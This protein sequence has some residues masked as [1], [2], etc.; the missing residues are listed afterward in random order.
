MATVNHLKNKDAQLRTLTTAF[1]KHVAEGMLCY[2]RTVG[3]SPSHQIYAYN[4]LGEGE[5]DGVE[6]VWYKGLNIPAADYT[7]HPGAKATDMTSGDQ[8]VDPLF[9][10]D[11]PH[12]RTAAIGYKIPSGIGD[13]DTK[14]SP[15]QDF[16]SICRTKKCYDYKGGGAI[17]GYGY[18]ANPAREIMQLATDYARLPNLPAQWAD[19]IEY[20]ISRIDWTNWAEWRDFCDQT[21]VVDYLEIP[22]FEGLGLTAEYYSG[23]NFDTFYT[24]RVEPVINL[25]TGNGSPA[26]GLSNDNF[27]ARFEGRI[28]PKYT[29]TYTFT[30]THDN[31][32]RLWINNLSTPLINQWSDAGTSTPGTHT[33]TI[34]LTAGQPYDIKL[35]W[36]NATHPSSFMLQWNS[37]TQ[38]L[39]V[40]PSKCLYPKIEDRPR[41]ES[42]VF[43]SSPT[44]FADS[45]RQILFLS[46]SIMQPVNGK[47]RFFC[48][49]QLTSSFDFDSS[50]MI[51][52]TFNFTN[53]NILQREPITEFEAKFRDLDSQYLEEPA[54]P[55]S[56]KVDGLARKTRENVKV[57][58]LFNMTN[59]QAWKV[60]KLRAKLETAGGLE[61]SFKGQGSKVYTPLPGDLVT[62]T[63]RKVG[64]SA[65]NFLLVE[66]TDDAQ[67]Q[68]QS[69]VSNRTFV[70][71]EW[72]SDEEE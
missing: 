21:E 70:A 14:N 19:Y 69:E 24:K 67:G 8:T 34:A 51:E 23:T 33:A 10:A 56:I 2:S 38:A 65:R 15:P 9:D 41:Y 59:W 46:N 50:N 35:E 27:S 31:G 64:E 22:D 16:S 17:D 52:G 5:W 44:N 26:V 1:G 68:D 63:H 7:F 12:S 43:F 47:L 20:W 6:G 53:R 40:V 66:A 45:I 18:T 60:L 30:L 36:N 54:T 3:T 39:Q 49:E 32:G 62:V 55:L 37:T 29:E 72:A 58:D 71:R 4:A 48:Y 57:L 28:V 25:Q 11:V 61:C 42:H 13:P